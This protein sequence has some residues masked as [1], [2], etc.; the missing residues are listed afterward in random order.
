MP[1][2][3]KGDSLQQLNMT[4]V[5][6]LQKNDLL[7]LV[8]V[9]LLCPV[10]YSYHFLSELPAFYGLWWYNPVRVTA[11]ID[12]NNSTLK[13]PQ[14]TMLRTGWQS[15][16]EKVAQDNGIE[17]I[18]NTVVKSI[19]REGD[20]APGRATTMTEGQDKTTI[21]EFDVLVVANNLRNSIQIM[22]DPTEDERDLSTNIQEFTLCATS[23][24]SDPSPSER[25]IELFPFPK[26]SNAFGQVFAQLNM[27]LVFDPDTPSRPG[28]ERRVV[29]QFL[30][31]PPRVEDTGM[32]KRRLK[33][34]FDDQ[35]VAKPSN[36]KQCPW[37][38]FPHYSAQDL[39]T[40]ERP[41]KLL[42][43]QGQN[44]TV[45]IGASAAIDSINEVLLYN[46][47]IFDQLGLA[48]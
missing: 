43:M 21:R 10:I 22:E 12:F 17:V 20:G 26:R 2:K 37:R 28:K 14:F 32:L 29:Y 9:F 13:V 39:A 1:P 31:R 23:F 4:F 48:A 15:L 46:K 6:F 7:S 42:D 47:Q 24:D 5:K 19:R 34:Y 35:G 45:Y 36:L 3:P 27:R 30:D 18:T 33:M 40:N 11:L 8:P 25:P 41:W 16:W 44:K 38:F